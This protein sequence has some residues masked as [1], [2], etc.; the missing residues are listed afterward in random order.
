MLLFLL[1]LLAICSLVIS[2]LVVGQI[3]CLK[4]VGSGVISLSVILTYGG[5][6]LSL[7]SSSSTYLVFLNFFGNF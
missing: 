3:C 1:N 7:F 2:L 6:S 4:D 5:A